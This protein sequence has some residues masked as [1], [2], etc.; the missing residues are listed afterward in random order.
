ML[1]TLFSIMFVIGAT[2]F[3]GAYAMIA[4]LGYELVDRNAFLQPAEFAA[5]VALGAATPGPLTMMVAFMG[6]RIAGWPGAVTSAI[7]VL[8]PGFAGSIALS[9]MFAGLRRSPLAWAV[10]R[11]LSAA[12]AGVLAAAVLDLASV[13]V[14]DG[15]SLLIAIL[16]FV[17]TGPLKRDPLFAIAAAVVFA[18]LP[19]P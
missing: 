1:W 7:G 19:S 11:G 12:V 10:V 15:V 3:G 4:P 9:K 17:I 13:V 2:S 5:G 16:A 14:T 6:Y 8:L 18:I